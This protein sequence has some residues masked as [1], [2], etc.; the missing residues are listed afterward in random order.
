[1]IEKL[2]LE[3]EVARTNA[4]A[5][6]MTNV[7]YAN[8]VKGTPSFPTPPPPRTFTPPAGAQ[9]PPGDQPPPG[10]DDELATVLRGIM[11]YLSK[12]QL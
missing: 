1:V 8:V 6:T 3:L 5:K 11:A 4:N 2:N 7:L 12:R 10:E 9:P